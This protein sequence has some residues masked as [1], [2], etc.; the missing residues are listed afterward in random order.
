MELNRNMNHGVLE[1]LIHVFVDFHDGSIIKSNSI[2]V[3]AVVWVWAC[4]EVGDLRLDARPWGMRL[5]YRC[6]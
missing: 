5:R 4:A 3:G 6:T 1:Q 2:R